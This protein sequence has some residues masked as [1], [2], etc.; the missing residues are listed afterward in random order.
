MLTV[1]RVLAVAAVAVLLCGAQS[2]AQTRLEVI[3][4][5][6]NGPGCVPG[7]EGRPLGPCNR[8]PG[9]L[10]EI[11]VESA[12]VTSQITIP[13]QAAIPR[14]VV[15][16]DGRYVLWASRDER[17]PA[18]ESAVALSYRDRVTNQVVGAF[19]RP[20]FL[21]TDYSEPGLLSHPTQLRA[22]A[23]PGP[24]LEVSAD[25]IREATAIP[26]AIAPHGSVA[27]INWQVVDLATG[28][29]RCTLP[30]AFRVVLSIDGSVGFTIQGTGAP[31]YSTILS[32]FDARTCLVQAQRDLSFASSG[33]WLDPATGRL[34]LA[35][36]F[37]GGMPVPVTAAFDPDSL[38][39]IGTVPNPPG[40]TN[41]QMV[42]DGHRPRAYRLFVEHITNF[43][44]FENRVDIIDTQSLT[45]I[46]AGALPSGQ[47][48]TD[49]AVVPVPPQPSDVRSS[50][51]GNQ[52][53][54]EWRA[55]AGPG[56]A[57]AYKI[58]AGSAPGLADLAT[59]QQGATLFVANGVPPGTYFVRVRAL[60]SGG[61]GAA[62]SELVVT[63]P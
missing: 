19:R 34:F 7:P 3:L 60:N 47:R 30:P 29:A 49:I 46:A 33:V 58:E 5:G 57:T 45:V 55:G 24:R 20:W 44:P 35:G 1:R 51:A 17:T 41:V 10:L 32:R 52:V 56:L 50:V 4:S 40:G 54:V 8:G 31:S 23:E 26:D 61:A 9:T 59:F 14:V 62:S 36:A 2:S 42:F 48:A 11:D 22:Y 38:T 12:T 39:L 25:G 43:G 18:G 6:V 27:V 53:T 21:S 37:L 15:T 16:A 63:V 13:E 28:A